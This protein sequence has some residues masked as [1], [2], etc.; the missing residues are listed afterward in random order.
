[1]IFLIEYDRAIGKLVQLKVF[2]D[3][4]ITIATDTRLELELEQMQSSNEH[5]IVI[6]EAESEHQIRKTHRRYFES[7]STLADPD[8]WILKRE[9]A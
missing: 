9:A 6:L 4:D 8:T 7:I 2:S 1:M 5:E 3:E